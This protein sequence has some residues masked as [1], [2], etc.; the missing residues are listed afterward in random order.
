MSKFTKIALLAVMAFSTL[1]AAAPAPAMGA[2]PVPAS[3]VFDAA[4]VKS[5]AAFASVQ[6]G[7]ASAGDYAGQATCVVA[8]AATSYVVAPLVISA[9][10]CIM[11]TFYLG[12]LIVPA[13]KAG[14]IAAAV[15][16]G[17]EPAKDFGSLYGKS[18]GHDACDKAVDGAF[19]AARSAK[20]YVNCKVIPG[21]KSAVKNMM[22][23]AFSLCS[24][25]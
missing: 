5:T 14:S 20:S 21:A 24:F 9:V 4:H 22:N 7:V 13:A 8:L 11:P 18:T 16:V 17:Y 2:A 10:F 15:I 3:A 6:S 1:N 19:T 23:A 25:F 12:A